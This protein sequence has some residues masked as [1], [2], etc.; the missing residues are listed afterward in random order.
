MKHRAEAGL[1]PLRVSLKWLSGRLGGVKKLDGLQQHACQNPPRLKHVTLLWEWKRQ[2]RGKKI[3][4]QSTSS[5]NRCTRT[6]L[7]YDHLLKLNG[8]SSMVQQAQST[9][10]L[11][12][13]VQFV[14]LP[15][16][17]FSL[18]TVQKCIGM[19]HKHTHT[20]WSKTP[21]TRSALSLSL[22]F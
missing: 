1:K 22:S 18:Y 8:N 13:N 12:K 17:S 4:T 10:L 16:C 7:G 3:K 6:L 15:P 14:P 19:L 9:P 11:T 2:R 21:E 5:V 20:H